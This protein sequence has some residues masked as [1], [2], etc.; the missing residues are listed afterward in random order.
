MEC[1]HRELPPK[2]STFEKLCKKWHISCVYIAEA[3][4][5]A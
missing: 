1:G 5:A 4:N 3:Q 2:I